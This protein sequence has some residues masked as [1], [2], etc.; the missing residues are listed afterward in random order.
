[1]TINNDFI[2]SYKSSLKYREVFQDI[3]TYVVFIGIGRNWTT[4]LGSLLD[5]HPNMVVANQPTFF[6]KSLIK[7]AIIYNEVR[8]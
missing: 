2:M 6:L 1:M 3:H 4:L 7:T 8:S 5:A